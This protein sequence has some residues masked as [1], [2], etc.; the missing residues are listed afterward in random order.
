MHLHLNTRHVNRGYL[1]LLL[2]LLN[3]EVPSFSRM[4][5]G[6]DQTCLGSQFFLNESVRVE[7]VN[8]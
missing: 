3:L 2:L 4:F 6:W 8:T 7:V 5:G 1:L